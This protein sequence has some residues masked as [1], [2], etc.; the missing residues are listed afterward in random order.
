MNNIEGAIKNNVVVI[1]SLKKS[2]DDATDEEKKN[3][4]LDT[5]E[6]LEYQNETNQHIMELLDSL[7]IKEFRNGK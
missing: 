2:V 7:A 3:V 1:E 5:I 6:D 4:L